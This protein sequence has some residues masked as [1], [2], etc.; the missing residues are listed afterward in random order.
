VVLL[1]IAWALS[2]ELTR[3]YGS[4]SASVAART[5]AHFLAGVVF[6]YYNPRLRTRFALAALG[7]GGLGLALGVYPLVAPLC[8]TYLVFWLAAV[9]PFRSFGKRDYS[10]GIY[11]YSFPIQ[12]SLAAF[13]L[14]AYGF[15]AYFG[16][17]FGLTLLCAAASWHLIER[18]A[19]KWKRLLPAGGG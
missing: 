19:L 6:Y 13:G 11:I 4:L 14:W 2:F 16:A 12:Q 9:L 5:S 15:A 1:A 7:L 17:S 3:R 10:Y 18:P 8:M